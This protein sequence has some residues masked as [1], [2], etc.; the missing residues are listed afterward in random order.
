MDGRLAILYQRLQ[1][2][3]HRRP[4]RKLRLVESVGLGE[5]RFVAV[6]QFEHLRYLIGGTG[7]SIAL[8]SQLPDSMPDSPRIRHEEEE[9]S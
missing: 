6:M 1:A 3:L 2:W 9:R 7:S 4:Q 8:L 5:K